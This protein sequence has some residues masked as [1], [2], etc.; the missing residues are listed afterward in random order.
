MSVIQE[1]EFEVGGLVS[2]LANGIVAAAQARRQRQEADRVQGWVDHVASEAQAA[3]FRADLTAARAHGLASRLKVVHRSETAARV[4]NESLEDE[5]DELLNENLA[6]RSRI[7][8]MAAELDVY[9][10]R[11]GLRAVR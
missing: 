7:K 2:G 1:L 4:E 11:A 8:V 9:R 5:V 6:L 3:G 10:R